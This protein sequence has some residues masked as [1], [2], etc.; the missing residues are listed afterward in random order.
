[1]LNAA[2][3]LLG[4]HDAQRLALICGAERLTYADLR[5]RVARCASA[6]QQHGL[7]PGGRVAIK[8]PDGCASVCAFLGAIWA[9]GV[10]VLINPRL[11]RT[12]WQALLEASDFR[13]VLAEMRDD[14]P[15]AFDDRMVLLAD[16]Q[17]AV[18]TA[19]AI[20]AVL[21]G[22]DE[23]AFWTCSSGTTGAP[24][25]ILHAQR[26]TL[27]VARASA[28]RLGIRAGDRLHASSRLFFCYPLAN[29]LMAGL[30]LGATVILD[31]QWPTAHSVLETIAAQT[32][33]VFFSVPS[34][35]R[36]LLR[37]GLAPQ[38]ARHGVRLCVSAGEALPVTLR[39]AWR[40]QTGLPI[41]DGY[42]AS[43]TLALVLIDTEGAGGLSPSPGV[44][45]DAVQATAGDAPTRIVIRTPTL[46]LGYWRRPEAQ[47]EA[48]RDGGFC[49]S[50]LF[51]RGAETTWRFAGRE[52]SL[53]K[54]RGRW[55]SLVELEERLA[56]CPGVAEAAAVALPDDDGV[57]AIAL[58]YVAES[59]AS[60]I[61]SDTL[62]TLTGTWPHHQR[63]HAIH[64]VATLPRTATGKLMRRSLAELHRGS[65]VTP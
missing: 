1:M 26:S 27:H 57:D 31:P 61:T 54:L 30:K 7:A 19:A 9:G 59:D 18:A 6:W 53:V 36:D 49:P 50:D 13:C 5:D 65:G 56:A 46:A 39:D 60:P 52:D 58:F 23:P 64:A 17:C 34:L 3:V 55:V 25:S 38:L 16:W 41:A 48:F 22:E 62:R 42:G 33:T 32:P 11:P 8:L 14:A 35:Y 12:E 44:Q 28:Q 43:E 24:K 2:Q 10:A 63:P 45:I 40:E 21:M 29:S 37:D 51:V 15:T 20:P 47:A 4:D